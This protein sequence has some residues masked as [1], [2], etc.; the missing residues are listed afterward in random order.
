MYFGYTYVYRCFRLCINV[1]VS[2]IE[3][4]L[5]QQNGKRTSEYETYNGSKMPIH[6]NKNE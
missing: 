3:I 6:N 1:S 5:P 4:C 2:S